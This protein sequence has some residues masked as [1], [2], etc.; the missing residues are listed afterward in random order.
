MLEGNFIGT[1]PTATRNLGNRIMG[2][3]V[4][5]GG[6]TVGGIQPGERNVIAYNGAVG[7]LVEGLARIRSAA[8]E[9]QR[10]RRNDSGQP[11]ASISTSPRLR[12]AR[13]R[14]IVGRRRSGANERQ[15]Y[16]IIT[17]AAP[18]GGG[19]RVIGT[20]NS[21]ASTTFDLDFYANSV[22]STGRAIFRGRVLPGLDPDDDRRLRQRGVQLCSSRRSRRARPS[23]AT[24][25]DPN[26]NTSELSPGIVF[27]VG[28]AWADPGTRQPDHR[29]PALRS[30]GDG[31][32]RRE[33][34]H[35][36]L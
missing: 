22:C 15:N 18:E 4:S 2:I 20:L 30:G 23:T 19:T 33:S 25:T 31:D 32:G 17:S 3:L 10:I 16:P 29:R 35:A 13:R 11:W 6:Q 8:T 9:C 21:L 34:G 24:A 1:D 7:V 28:P 36:E 26:G 14:T 5:T 12:A 27:S